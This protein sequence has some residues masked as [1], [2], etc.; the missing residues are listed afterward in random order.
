MNAER[1][2]RSRRPA[3]E[4]EH[5]LDLFVEPGAGGPAEPATTLAVTGAK[6]GVGKTLLAA[7][8]AV[9]LATIGRRTVLLDA[10]VRGAGAHG[11]L[12][13]PH[14][15]G[16][17]PYAPPLPAFAPA[18][19]DLAAPR[20]PAPV[21]LGAES[22]RPVPAG[23]PGLWLW[24][25]GLDERPRGSRRDR[26]R[27][28]IGALVSRLEADFA[29]IDLGD[30]L[31]RAL[32]RGWLG[33]D[34]RLFVTL[35]EP[36]SVEGTY[37][38]AR[39]AFA[40]ELLDAQ[41]DVLT[42]RRLAAALR[43]LGHV[44]APL[45]LLR[46]LNGRG[47]VSLVRPVEEA[48]GAFRFP[49][50]V[51]QSRVR[52]DLDLGEHMVSAARRRLGLRLR[53]FGHVDYD[54]TVHHC[55]RNGRP[56]LVESPGTKA[57]RNVERIARRLLARRP[58]RVGAGGWVPPESHH[59]VLEVDRGATDE[60]VRRA[61]KRAREIYAPGSPSCR[62]LVDDVGLARLRARVEEAHDVLLDPA[63]RRPYELSVFPPEPEQRPTAEEQADAPPPPPPPTITPETEFTGDLLRAVRESQGVS[64]EAISQ[65]T[66][67]GVP[68]LEA[69]ETDDYPRLPA[70]VYVR[71]FV[72]ELAKFL[73]LD[74]EHVSRTYVRRLARH[75][76]ESA[77][78]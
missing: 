50:V 57:S 34:M 6:G 66:K 41:E 64:L 69:L 62:G 73:K 40:R 39:A 49:F 15:R 68:Y 17:D 29:V 43:E 70:R 16:L 2:E 23:V 18:E 77:S 38:F 56:L 25:A 75:L 9:Y 55:L 20:D 74:P 4:S 10:D 48:M 21:A 14:P 65:K 24:H 78:P 11:F 45:D 19:P 36:T 33:A 30:G 63:R 58:V 32:L 60:E 59:D 28:V 1:G 8:L 51:N 76:G 27:R 54:D 52:G 7:N 37:R 22:A 3:G 12:G 31:D 5:G 42:R 67:I 61:Y 35:P 44:P 13:V 72:T 53:Y 47:E 46:Y 71:G 26:N